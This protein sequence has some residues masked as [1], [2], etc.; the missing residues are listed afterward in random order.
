MRRQLRDEEHRKQ[1]CREMRIRSGILKI[2]THTLLI[3]YWKSLME[4]VEVSLHKIAG[5][6]SFPGNDTEESAG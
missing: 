4:V 1:K 5:M 2:R 6:S 3:D